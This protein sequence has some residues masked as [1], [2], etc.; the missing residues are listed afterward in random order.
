M[1][2]ET[3]PIMSVSWQ[4]SRQHGV[5]LPGLGM[6]LLSLFIAG[7]AV[8]ADGPPARAQQPSALVVLSV[9]G[10]GFS[11]G[12][13]IPSDQPLDLAD[14]QMISL[15]APSGRMVELKGPYSDIPMPEA[16]VRDPDSLEALKWL[17]RERTT[18]TGDM[19]AT[20]LARVEL[21]DPWAVDVNSSGHRCLRAGKRVVLWRADAAMDL[22]VTLFIQG[23]SWKARAT[24]PAGESLLLAPPS[25]PAVDGG[26]LIVGF[27]G[28]QADLSVSLLPASLPTDAARLAW[29]MQVQCDDQ[30]AALARRLP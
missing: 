21:P 22:P 17:I 27:P 8:M 5:R 7:A 29:M 12:D 23:G 30:A 1:V 18:D 13:V 20:R 25:L 26:H 24:W 4:R 6:L 2:Q 3:A 28:G 16:A 11:P 10:G 19:G 9:Q 15:I 14:G